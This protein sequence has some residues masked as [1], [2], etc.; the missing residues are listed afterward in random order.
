MFRA[1]DLVRINLRGVDVAPDVDLDEVARRTEG[2]SGDDL[3]NICRDASALCPQPA[4]GEAPC[5]QG[6]P[7][8]ALPADAVFA[9]A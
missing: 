8:D 5:T 9:Q 2:Y 7:P 4:C 3:T 6:H 1:Q